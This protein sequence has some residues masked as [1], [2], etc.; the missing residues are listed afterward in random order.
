MSDENLFF[1]LLPN[2]YINQVMLCL[3]DG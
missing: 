3:F 2:A 1:I